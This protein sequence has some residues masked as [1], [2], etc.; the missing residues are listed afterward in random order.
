VILRDSNFKSLQ[1]TLLL[2]GRVY[3]VTSYVEGNVDFVWGTGVTYFDR[4]EIKT[5]GRAGAIVQARNST[6]YGY[7]FVDS[8]LTAGANVSGQVLARIDATCIQPATSPTSTANDGDQR[9]RLDDHASRYELR[10]AACVSGSTKHRCQWHTA[11]REWTRPGLP[12]NLGQPGRH[13]ARQKRPC[14]RLESPITWPPFRIPDPARATLPSRA[15]RR[16]AT[17]MP[18]SSRTSRAVTGTRSAWSGIATRGSC[19]A[20]C[21]AP[22]ARTSAAEDLLQEVF[23]ALYRGA[24]QI[25]TAGPARLS[26]RSRGA[27]RRAELRRRAVQSQ[28]HLLQ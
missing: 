17:A 1:D 21:S 9:Q 25:R 14:S 28:K 8:K 26:D 12:A 10:P 13:D 23:L 6:G 18:S 5:V 2:S 3:V 16:I 22:S 20:C 27:A 15:S 11:E 4:S 7:V 19:A 24:G